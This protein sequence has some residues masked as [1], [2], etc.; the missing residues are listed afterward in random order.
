M[1]VPAVLWAYI[2]RRA[3]GLHQWATGLASQSKCTSV[4]LSIPYTNF[5]LE[6]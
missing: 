2:T 3:G 6:N 5:E 1:R 4:C